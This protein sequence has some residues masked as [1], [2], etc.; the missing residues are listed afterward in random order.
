MVRI[1]GKILESF[2]RMI[3][4]IM[5]VLHPSIQLIRAIGTPQLLRA[6][7]A[8][9]ITIIKIKSYVNACTKNIYNGFKKMLCL[10]PFAPDFAKATTGRLSVST[11]CRRSFNVGARV[12]NIHNYVS[13]C[14]VK[15][16]VT[17]AISSCLYVPSYGA[18]TLHITDM[19]RQAVKEVQVG[20]PFLLTVAVTDNTASDQEL[21]LRGLQ[22]LYVKRVGSRLLNV[23]GKKSQEHMYQIRIDKKGYYTIGPAVDPATGERSSTIGIKATTANTQQKLP[24]RQVALP[25][26]ST[27]T[28]LRLVTDKETVYVGQKIKTFLRFYAP[29]D[30]ELSI[31]QVTA[32]DPVT[33]NVSEKLGPKKGE[34]EID[35]KKYTYW[36]WQWDMFA[37]EPGQLVIPSYILDYAK[38]LALDN[39][40]GSWASFFGP[41][42]EHKRVYS[43]ALTL[44]VKPLPSYHKEVQAVG[45]FTR[46]TA[47]IDP[48]RA[49]QYEGMVLKITLEGSGNIEHLRAPELMLPEGFK[50]YASKEYQRN[51][52]DKQQKIFEYIVQGLQPGDWE[53]PEQIFT[54]FDVEMSAYKELKTAP[55]LVAIIPENSAQ[56]IAYEQSCAHTQTEHKACSTL[57]YPEYLEAHN[58]MSPMAWYIFLVIMLLPLG[59]LG[60][61]YARDIVYYYL[62]YY[63][64]FYVR[65]KAYNHAHKDI[66]AACKGQ[67]VYQL[68]DIFLRYVAA[69]TQ[70][71]QAS[72]T[73]SDIVALFAVAE[74]Y[75]V[76]SVDESD[77]NHA[78]AMAK[79]GSF[80]GISR[81]TT[82]FKPLDAS[83]AQSSIEKKEAAYTFFN[84]IA[85]IAYAGELVGNASD[86]CNN[87]IMWLDELERLLR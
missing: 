49:Q 78:V 9:R 31:E 55:L 86:V 8:G 47:Q 70:R 67:S 34:Q 29:E 33:I 60:A 28:F 75:G 30:E 24:E 65:R 48:P 71:S 61:L 4:Q 41:K 6:N 15:K 44:Q 85:E 59:V 66:I 81:D 22:D 69:V 62:P 76:R 14:V 46:Y 38:H 10:T 77:K 20:E 50:W 11:A 13:N 52:G 23:N 39:H 53:I 37:Q 25:K 27:G 83:F 56:P 63:V 7:G 64:P 58:A 16:Y 2:A 19:Q 3:H 43:N 74:N 51:V 57:M 40:L 45:S 17:I 18:I 36:Q 5:Y 84:H 73:T 72:L 12:W 26:Q 80:G 42:Y 79:E 82:D 87:A 1:V 68:H 21:Q 32:Q 35:G 54:F